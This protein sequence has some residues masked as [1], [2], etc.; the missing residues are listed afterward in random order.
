MRNLQIVLF[1][2]ISTSTSFGQNLTTYPKSHYNLK[3]NLA[4]QGY[5]PVAYFTENEAQEGSAKI[6]STYKGVVYHFASEKNKALFI[7]NS[8]KYEPQYGGY[9]AY[10]IASGDKVKI[11]PETFKIQD[12]RLLL[13][14][15][16]RSINTLTEWDKDEST[17]LRDADSE[18]LKIIKN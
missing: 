13:F 3:S 12:G 2:I 8:A 1:L 10:A 17:F 4:I 15:N 6:S 5:D 11:D 9:C 7:A 16:F 18:W 14:Y